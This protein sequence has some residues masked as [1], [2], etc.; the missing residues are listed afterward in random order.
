M[1]RRSKP[2]IDWE[3]ATFG[4]PLLDLGSPL[5]Y[6]V[7]AN[8][9]KNL[10]TQSFGLT[11]RPGNLNREQLVE[12]YV[13]KSGCPVGNTVFYFAYGRL[14]IAV[15]AQQICARHQQRLTRDARFA[16]LINLVHS[17][18]T[19]GILSIEKQRI[20]RLATE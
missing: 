7:G 12:H 1:A 3:M 2:S 5:G 11:T 9:P 10:R 4:D 17:A 13:A 8:H 19:T 6:W 16:V 14:Q 15:I 18:G 20:T